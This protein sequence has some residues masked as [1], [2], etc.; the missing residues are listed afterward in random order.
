M[1]KKPFLSQASAAAKAQAR[2][3]IFQRI[4]ARYRLFKEYVPEFYR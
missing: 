3:T 4:G 2:I 1:K